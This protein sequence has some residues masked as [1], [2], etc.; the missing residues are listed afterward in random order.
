MTRAEDIRPCDLPDSFHIQIG[1]HPMRNYLFDHDPAR[2]VP[3]CVPEAAQAAAQATRRRSRRRAVWAGL[4]FFVLIAALAVTTVVLR[5]LEGSLADHLEEG[6]G[7]WEYDSEDPYFGIVPGGFD[8]WQKGGTGIPKAPAGVEPLLSLSERGGASL[9]AEEIYKKVLPS[10]VSV[11]AFGAEFGSAGSGIVLS[12]DGYII[13]NYHVIE[14]ADRATVTPL[15]TGE[16]SPAKLVGYDAEMDVAVLKINKDGLVPA[17]FG[18]SRDLAP[19]ETVYAI[20]NPMGYL[21]GT[22]TDGIV[23]YNRRPVTVG[24][25]SMTLIQTNAALNSGNSGGALV[26]RWGQVVGITV[27]KIDPHGEITTEGLGLAIPV[28]EAKRC[29]NTL[30]RLGA[31]ERPSIGILCQDQPDGSGVLVLTVNPGSTAEEAGLRVGDVI[32]TAAGRSADNTD[33]FKDIIYELGVGAEMDCTVLRDEEE[34]DLVL[35]LRES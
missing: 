17:E 16:A 28:S 18:A 33:S 11:N 35:K 22:I 4:L 3:A 9:S 8:R 25:Y 1:G 24:G 15:S 19:G 7:D 5:R 26:N 2:M 12:A 14:G 31:M 10:V 13:T 34:L 29:V 6:A 30:L 27:A 21:Y 20:G 23:S 32:L